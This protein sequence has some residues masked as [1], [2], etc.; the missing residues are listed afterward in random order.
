MFS[1]ASVILFGGGVVYPS[2]HWSR[3]PPCPVHAGIHTP[4]WAD[5]TPPPDGHCSGWYA[6]YWNAF[7]FCIK[8]VSSPT[9]LMLGRGLSLHHQK[10]PFTP[11]ES[12]SFLC[13]FLFFPLISFACSFY[14]LQSLREGNVFTPVCQSFCSQGGVLYPSMQWARG[15]HSARQTPPLSGQTLPLWADAPQHGH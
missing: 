10:G 6:S 13:C 11:S 8:L 2:M 9:S 14:D 15:V 7:L 1:Q 4:A 3:H 5:R 12:D